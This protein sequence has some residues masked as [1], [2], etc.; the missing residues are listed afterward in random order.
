[1]LPVLPH[2]L[3]TPVLTIMTCTAAV[4]ASAASAPLT[5]TSLCTIDQNNT[6]QLANI[7]TITFLTAIDFSRQQ[8][9]C[10]CCQSPCL[11]RVVK[12][13]DESSNVIVFTAMTAHYS[14]KLETV[15]I[16]R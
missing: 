4:W 5:G 1:M 6:E 10:R 9:C 7:P 12:V 3:G 14:K 16:L 2:T 11:V 8:D 13:S 15:G